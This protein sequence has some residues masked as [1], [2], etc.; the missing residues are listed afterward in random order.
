MSLVECIYSKAQEDSV[1]INPDNDKCFLFG[2]K[3]KSHENAELINYGCK[4]EQALSLSAAY[5][6]RFV[7]NL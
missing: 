6:T 5:I 4:V 2:D 1:K 7:I 3:K